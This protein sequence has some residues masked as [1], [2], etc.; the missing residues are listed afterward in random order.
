MIDVA[1]LLLKALVKNTNLDSLSLALCHIV[2]L[3]HVKCIPVKIGQFPLLKFWLGIFFFEDP[4]C[5]LTTRCHKY[6]NPLPDML[7]NLREY[8]NDITNIYI[9]RY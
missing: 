6:P 7:H 2:F 8:N 3:N 5:F 4:S 9:Y 1:S